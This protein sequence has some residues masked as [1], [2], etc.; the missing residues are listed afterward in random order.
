MAYSLPTFNL[1]INVWRRGSAVFNPPDV[2]G[3][4]NL[5][6]GRRMLDPGRLPEPSLPAAGCSYVLVPKL[7]D[8]RDDKVFPGHDNVEVPAGSGR[9]YSVGWVEDVGKGFPNEHRMAVLL[10]DGVSLP[11]WP[12]PI[13]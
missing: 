7:F 10:W 9:F 5:T 13:P 2:T 11:Y 3:M 6:P 4:C 12:G 1:H 8:I